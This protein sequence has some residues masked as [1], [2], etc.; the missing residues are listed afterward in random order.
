MELIEKIESPVI[1]QI[2][3]KKI[4]KI[5][6][7]PNLCNSIS[8]VISDEKNKGVIYCVWGK[9]EINREILKYGVRFS[10]PQCPNAL[11]LSVTS[12]EESNKIE[13]RCTTN[14]D[15]KDEDF[16]DSIREFVSDWVVGIKEFSC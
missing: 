4:L 6:H 14:T 13:I 15:I 8:T 7:L 10:F 1:D 12:E 3:L 2:S 9:H 16:I 11:T 5:N